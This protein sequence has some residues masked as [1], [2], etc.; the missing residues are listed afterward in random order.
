MIILRGKS[1]VITA[2]SGLMVLGASAAIGSASQ[3]A[4]VKRT[5]VN[6]T[7]K[8][9]TS[10]ADLSNYVYDTVDPTS[11]NHHHYLTPS[12]FADKFSQSTSYI[13][14]FKDYLNKYH[15]RSYAYPGN[16]AMKLT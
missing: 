6:V 5:V 3:A 11:P 2:L 9:S 10:E 1:F 13:Q 12:E 8:P 15:I 16:L 7:F 14:S 4:T